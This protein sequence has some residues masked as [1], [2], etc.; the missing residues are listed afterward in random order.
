MRIGLHVSMAGGG[1]VPYAKRL[2]CTTMQIF[3]SSPQSYRRT[4]IDE[5]ALKAFRAEHE[6][7][8]LAHA[9]PQFD[10]TY[11]VDDGDKAC[12]TDHHGADHSYFL[13]TACRK[14]VEPISSGGYDR[15]DKSCGR[16]LQREQRRNEDQ[17][18]N[19]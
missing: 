10:P 7:A 13:K 2:G 11:A 5:A 1:A 17:E 9:P 19:D 15:N 16:K 8:D 4:P 6:A 14:V 3:T 18:I 12:E